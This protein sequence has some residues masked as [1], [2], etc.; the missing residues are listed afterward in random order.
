[1]KD[2]SSLKGLSH[3]PVMLKQV[4]NICDPKNG[5]VFVD[6]TY[7]AGGYTNAILSYPNTKVIALDR[8]SNI[9]YLAQETKKKFKNRFIFHNSKFSELHKI[10]SKSNKVDCIIFDLGLSSLQISDLKR[11]FSFNSKDEPDMR[12]GL[13]INTAKEV[14][15]NLDSETLER[16]FRLLGEEKDSKRISKKIL[17]ERKLNIIKTV[18]DLVNI[19]KKSKRKN[20]KKKINISTQ[21]F[22]ALR[23]FVNKEVTELI[24]G[25]INASRILKEGGKIIIIT[26]H[27][28]EDKIVKFFFSNFSTNKANTS[29]YMPENKDKKILFKNYKNE[30]LKPDYFEVEENNP[31]RSAKLRHAVRSKHDFIYPDELKIKFSNY[32]ELEKVNV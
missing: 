10:V 17:S 24:E 15:N 12:M 11:G 8:D 22:Q 4:L 31:S 5:G 28:L 9:N 20:F 19:I 13:N 25:L 30:V 26:F 32:L 14:L 2:V 18:P 6:C 7:G 23:I 29:R 27:S 16:I 3:Y 21:V 1:M